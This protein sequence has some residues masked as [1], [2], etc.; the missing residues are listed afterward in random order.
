KRPAAVLDDPDH[1]GPR[2][3]QGRHPAVAHAAEEPGRLH[4]D[5]R[6]QAA[7]RRQRSQ[8]GQVGEWGVASGQ[9]ICTT[10]HSPKRSRAMSSAP[11]VQGTF[12]Q[13]F[14]RAVKAW[15]D[16]F[17]TPRDPTTLG[18]MRIC[19]G[20]FILYVHLAHTPDLY[21]LFAPDG[22]ADAT[23]VDDL[24]KNMPYV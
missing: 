3:G 23:M 20:I 19:A 6:R 5:R 16:F 2:P 24:R 9:R 1:L 12:R 14:Q 11:T 17:F 15:N 7:Q 13:T 10:Y 4:L 8:F 22:W 18:L 21:N